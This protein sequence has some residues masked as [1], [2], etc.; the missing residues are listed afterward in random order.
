[1]MLDQEARAIA[2]RLGLDRVSEIIAK[3]LAGFGPQITAVGLGGTKNAELHHQKRGISGKAT[4]P[5]CTCSRPSSAQ[6]CSVGNTLPGLSRPCA[7][8]AHLSRCC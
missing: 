1:M 7:S 2:E 4:L 5:A 8:K 6:R 3:A